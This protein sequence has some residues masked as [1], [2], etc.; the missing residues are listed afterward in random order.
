[1]KTSKLILS[2]VLIL[3][4]LFVTSSFVSAAN[5][6]PAVNKVNFGICIA[7]RQKARNIVR[8]YDRQEDR[9]ILNYTR[10]VSLF[11]AQEA[12]FSQSGKDTTE[13]QNDIA[14]LKTLIDTLKSD[15]DS[16]KEMAS[17]FQSLSCDDPEWQQ[18]VTDMFAAEKKIFQDKRVIETFIRTDINPDL[19]AL[20]ILPTPTPSV[21]PSPTVTPTP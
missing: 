16:L 11:E 15:I 2:F 14:T 1:M 8:F 4:G 19:A 3:S 21:T 10:R 9:M 18:A 12:N 20:R 7:R 13:L 17:G 5:G 6:N